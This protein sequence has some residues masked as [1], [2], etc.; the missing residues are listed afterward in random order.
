MS[1]EVIEQRRQTRWLDLAL[2]ELTRSNAVLTDFAGRLSHDLKTPLTAVLGFAEVLETLPAVED[3]LRAA[4][5]VG[6]I[7]RSGNRMRVLIDDLLSFAAV[8]GSG[9]P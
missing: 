5:Y 3:D 2:S 4:R 9:R 6:R 8:G 7:V 1:V